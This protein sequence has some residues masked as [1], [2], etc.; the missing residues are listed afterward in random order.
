MVIS[1]GLCIEWL[2][3]TEVPPYPATV[4]IRLPLSYNS[5]YNAVG[6]TMEDWADGYVTT[7]TVGTADLTTVLYATGGWSGTLYNSGVFIHCIGY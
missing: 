1:N 5:F 4:G 7:A 6:C 3:S 2:K